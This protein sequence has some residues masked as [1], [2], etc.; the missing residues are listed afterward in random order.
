MSSG[1]GSILL[2][3]LD[4]KILSLGLSCLTVNIPLHVIIYN[5][6]E[7]FF[8]SLAAFFLL[9][10]MSFLHKISGSKEKKIYCII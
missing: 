8:P 2:Y 10:F 5:G 7:W 9:H 1:S 4:Q 3:L 6:F